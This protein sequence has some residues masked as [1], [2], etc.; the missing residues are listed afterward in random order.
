MT[1]SKQQT[2]PQQEPQNRCVAAVLAPAC[3]DMSGSGERASYDAHPQCITR[4]EHLKN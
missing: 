1:P 2:K 3:A 4:K